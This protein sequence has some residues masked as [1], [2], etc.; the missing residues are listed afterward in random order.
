MIG[1][2]SIFDGIVD[3]EVA[4]QAPQ[5]DDTDKL[6][7]SL[8]GKGVVAGDTAVDVDVAGNIGVVGVIDVEVAG[9]A[10]QLD[11]TD[12]LAVSLYGNGAAAG[13][14]PVDV[15]TVGNIGVVLRSSNSVSPLSLISIDDGQAIPGG[16]AVKLLT[17]SVPMLYNGTG[18]ATGLDRQRNNQ[19]IVL[20]ASAARTAT[21]QSADIVNYNGSGLILFLNVSAITATPTITLS[22]QIKDSISGNYFTIWTAAAGVSTVVSRAYLFTPGGAAGSYTEA[23]NLRL[24]RTWRLNVAHTDADS[25]TYSVSAVVLV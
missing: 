16:G 3:V 19:E 21:L 20:L 8:Y 13:D 12:K 23:V 11:D 22:L 4:G 25:I 24:A 10:P 2:K 14:T 9:Q 17:G 7:V 6:A 15:D 18:S 1:S 5:L